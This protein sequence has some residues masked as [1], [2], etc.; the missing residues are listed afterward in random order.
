MIN[1]L[2]ILLPFQNQYLYHSLILFTIFPSNEFI[3]MSLMGSSSTRTVLLAKALAMVV[4]PVDVAVELADAFPSSPVDTAVE[5]EFATAVL[6]R[7]RLF[8]IDGSADNM[9]Q[10]NPAHLLCKHLS[11]EVD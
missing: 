10:I 2:C 11:D 8:R 7:R 5:E 6:A 9:P 4:P 3:K 1:L